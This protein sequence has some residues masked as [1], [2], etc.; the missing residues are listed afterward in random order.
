MNLKW[1]SQ[2]NDCWS[3][4][5][6]LGSNHA[7]H[8]TAYQNIMYV[9]R[10]S[11]KSV[12]L[13]ETSIW[14]E[15]KISSYVDPLLLYDGNLINKSKHIHNIPLLFD[16]LHISMTKSSGIKTIKYYTMDLQCRIRS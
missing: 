3:I 12:K 10:F 9:Y 2:A 7:A 11:L 14:Y 13:T 5:V 1:I 16:F 4:Y 8:S 6:N 15:S